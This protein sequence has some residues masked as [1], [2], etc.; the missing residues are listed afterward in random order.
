MASWVSH[1]RGNRTRGNAVAGRRSFWREIQPLRSEIVTPP[2][3]FLREVAQ[4]AAASALS[5]IFAAKIV[6]PL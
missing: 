1:A 5:R 3:L 4:C 6:K 2:V